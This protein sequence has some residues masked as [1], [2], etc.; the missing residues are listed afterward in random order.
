VAVV[1]TAQRQSNLATS[2]VPGTA[3]QHK[4]SR[5][6]LHLQL[7]CITTSRY[8]T[9]NAAFSRQLENQEPATC[10]KCSKQQ[11]LLPT[12]TS[13]PLLCDRCGDTHTVPRWHCNSQL[14]NHTHNHCVKLTPSGSADVGW[15]ATRGGRKYCY[16]P[17]S[18]HCLTRGGFFSN[19]HGTR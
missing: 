18:G 14:T 17:G 3:S 9:M 10:T 13:N 2:P 16:L 6:S 15:R 12:G 8:C 5:Q 1:H 7:C 19:K 4:G 11:V